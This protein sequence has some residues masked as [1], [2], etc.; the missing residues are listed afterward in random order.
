MNISDLKQRQSLPLKQKVSL[1][2][3][4]IKTFCEHMNGKV[5]VSF[6]GGKDSTVMLDIVRS[7]YPDVPAVFIDTGLEYPEIKEFVRTKDN[8]TTIRPKMSFKQVLEKYGYPV[9]SKEQALY[10]R[11]YRTT[12]SDYLKN[13]RWNG[14]NGRF[15]ISEKWKFLVNAPFMVSEKCCDIMKK[16]PIHKYEKQTGLKPFIGTMA[17]DSHGRERQYLQNGC[18]SFK[19]GK[20]KSM[21]LGFWLERDVWDY[22]KQNNLDYA[23]IYDKGIDRTGC[24]FCMFGCHLEKND[25]FEQLKKTHP[26]LHEYC[27]NQLGLKEVI[28]YVKSGGVGRGET[29]PKEE[30]KK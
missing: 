18:N 20:E 19:E 3:Q 13:V 25:R 26:E 11:E 21:P 6:S 16:R 10:I 12:K 22:I 5:Y 29:P 17:S 9:V 14:K 7:V 23:S 15:K 1:S 8:V 4:R 28:D 30:V 2:K 27:M 24:I